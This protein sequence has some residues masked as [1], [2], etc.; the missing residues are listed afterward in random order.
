MRAGA[1]GAIAAVLLAAGCAGA[2]LER[3]TARLATLTPG[4]PPRLTIA[5]ERPDC[6]A[7]HHVETAFEPAAVEVGV[8]LVEE[9]GGGDCAE[10]RA[11]AVTVTLR[12]P[13]RG[14]PVVDVSG[15][16]VPVLGRSLVTSD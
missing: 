15:A 16:D 11:D 1:V 2:E 12:E 7:V 3:T 6:A 13:L 9:D 14:R 4:D 8:F 10:R 5:F